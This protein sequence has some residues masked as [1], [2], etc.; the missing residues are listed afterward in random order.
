VLQTSI[1]GDDGKLAAIMIQSPLV[2]PR[3]PAADGEAG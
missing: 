1:D 2:V 3:E